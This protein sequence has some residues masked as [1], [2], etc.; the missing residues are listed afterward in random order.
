MSNGGFRILI[1]SIWNACFVEPCCIHADKCQYLIVV[2][3]RSCKF[4]SSDTNTK[5]CRRVWLSSIEICKIYFIEHWV[6]TKKSLTKSLNGPRRAFTDFSPDLRRVSSPYVDAY[7]SRYMINNV[8]LGYF[9]LNLWGM[10]YSKLMSN[11]H[12]FLFLLL[13]SENI[14]WNGN[15]TNFLQI[16]FLEININIF[17]L[18]MTLVGWIDNY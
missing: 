13:I 16:I 6:G 7:G 1:S 9:R 5:R 12:T 4:Q 8:Y 10:L 3:E 17:L 2:V 15:N 18:T 14:K 11:S